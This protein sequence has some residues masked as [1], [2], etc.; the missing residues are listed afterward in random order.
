MLGG[1]VADAASKWTMSKAGLHEAVRT[2]A[3]STGQKISH[4]EKEVLKAIAD[5]GGVK[6]TNETQ[7][8]AVKA[9]S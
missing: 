6:T 2:H 1:D 8:R 9:A 4:V 7:V 3:K 5:A